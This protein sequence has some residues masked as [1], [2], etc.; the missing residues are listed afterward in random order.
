[1]PLSPRRGA[2]DVLEFKTI[3]QFDPEKNRLEATTHRKSG[4]LLKTEI[5]LFDEQGR[6]AEY[7]QSDGPTIPFS[8]QFRR[9]YK[10]DV[11]G[12]LLESIYY[13]KD[14]KVTSRTR[15][16]SSLDAQGN[17]IKRTEVPADANGKPKDTQFTSVRAITY[18]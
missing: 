9:Q 15:F 4:E 2:D 13:G 7:A 17:W 16:Q 12:V 10:R 18:Y 1:M 11:N 3:Y 14:G 5:Y 6:I 8:S